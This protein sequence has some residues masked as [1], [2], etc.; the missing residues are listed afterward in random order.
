MLGIENIKNH[1]AAEHMIKIT[2]SSELVSIS[3]IPGSRTV[4]RAIP[5]GKPLLHKNTDRW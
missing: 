1:I 2:A 4:L 3:K 5:T